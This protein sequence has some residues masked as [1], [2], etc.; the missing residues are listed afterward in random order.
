MTKP[1][2]WQNPQDVFM[3]KSGMTH[4]AFLNVKAGAIQRRLEPGRQS[5]NSIQ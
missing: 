1:G 2:L 4:Y 3:D 5:G